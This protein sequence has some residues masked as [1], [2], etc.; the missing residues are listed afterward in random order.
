MALK[1]TALLALALIGNVYSIEWKSGFELK[2]ANFLMRPS[3]QL[4]DYA[5]WKQRL[6][7]GVADGLATQLSRFVPD[8]W[9]NA[10]VQIPQATRGCALK[11]ADEQL[12]KFFQSQP[13]DWAV[14]GARAKQQCGPGYAQLEQLMGVIGKDLAQLTPHVAN[15]YKTVANA[16]SQN[17]IKG[18]HAALVNYNNNWINA[19]PIDKSTIANVIPKIAFYYNGPYTDE[20]GQQV[21][22]VLANNFRALPSLLVTLN[23]VKKYADGTNPTPPQG[24]YQAFH[25]ALRQDLA[26]LSQM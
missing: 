6:T 15:N 16:M 4:S 5:G 19:Q 25:A 3:L 20:L 17:G 22:Q 10:F 1:L 26:A 23:K 9:L 18:A 14:V 21:H 8:D 12:K 7:D 11:L 24:S 2:L 13:I